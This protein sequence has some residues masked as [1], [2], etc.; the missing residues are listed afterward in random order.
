[1]IIPLSTL[2]VV[3]LE[4][5]QSRQYSTST[6]SQPT[7]VEKLGAAAFALQALSSCTPCSC[8]LENLSIYLGWKGWWFIEP[9]HTDSVKKVRREIR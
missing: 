1:M 4:F 9:M 8:Y 7:E 2:V 6:T 5:K 3:V